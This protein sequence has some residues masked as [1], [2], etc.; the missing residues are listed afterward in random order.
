MQ[1]DR[2]ALIQHEID[3]MNA[4]LGPRH[5]A[6]LQEVI[7]NDFAPSVRVQSIHPP[8]LPNDPAKRP[9]PPFPQGVN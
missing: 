3:Q 6:K 4:A 1:K 5:A 9:L 7:E 2:E 8:M